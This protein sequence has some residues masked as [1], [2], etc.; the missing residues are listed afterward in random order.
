MLI[1]E[2]L[3]LP[4]GSQSIFIVGIDDPHYYGCDDLQLAMR[5]VPRES[6]KLL[7]VHTPE[8]IKEAHGYGIDLYLC[9]HTHGGQICLPIIG[10]IFVNANC[11]RKF[12]RGTW[13]YKSLKGYTSAGVGSSG[14]PVRFFCPRKLA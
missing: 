9:G 2:S 10:P 8:I 12:T 14:V 7:M 11:A 6:F 5:G 3:E 4:L 13:Q 1:N